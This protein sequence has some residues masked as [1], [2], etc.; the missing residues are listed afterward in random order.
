[1]TERSGVS[2]AAGATNEATREMKR[3]EN[4]RNEV[5]QTRYISFIDV[6]MY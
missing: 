2:G 6:L 3:R 1:M 5:Y 4:A